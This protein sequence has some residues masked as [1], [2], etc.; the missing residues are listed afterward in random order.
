MRHIKRNM[1]H[2]E[3]KDARIKAILPAP[4]GLKAKIGHD[5]ETGDIVDDVAYIVFW[6]EWDCVTMDRKDFD[7]GAC[8]GCDMA[9]VTMADMREGFFLLSDIR[10]HELV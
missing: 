8:D 10:N 3:Y 9:Y 7:L 1:K 5:P 6:Y 2:G 4:P